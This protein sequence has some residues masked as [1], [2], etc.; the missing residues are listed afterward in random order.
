MFSA[1]DHSFRLDN[2]AFKKGNIILE[3]P[4]KR[5]SGPEIANMLDNLVLN[6]NEDEFVGYGEE[7]NWT[8]KYALWEPL[9]A[10]ALILM[11]NIDVMHQ[12]HNIGE[13]ILST[14]NY[15]MDKTKDN[16]KPR[17][18]LAQLCNWPS[19]ELKSSGGKPRA[20][21]CLKPKER[22]EVLFW[23]HNLK[24]SYGYAMGFRRA[25]NLETGKLSGLK[26]HDYRIFMERLLPVMFHE[27]LND[28]VWKALA[29]LSHFYRQLCAKEIKKEMMEKLEKEILVLICKLE[30]VFPPGWF[31]PMQHLLVHLLYEANLGDPQQYRWMYHI[32]RALNKLRAMVRNKARVKDCIAE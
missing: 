15:F 9:Y 25:V 29:E 12:E 11:H 10:K 28:D 21:F 26:S 24:F 18:D 22:K 30:K 8:H 4:P 5:L 32:E 20:S 1:L 6:K 23:L 3:G 16:H 7:H 19:L 2:N 13:S 17:K 27:Y 14:C 31:N